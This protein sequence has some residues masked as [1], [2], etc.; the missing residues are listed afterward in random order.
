MN[1]LLGHLN[2]LPLSGSDI[3]SAIDGQA[4]VIRYSAIHEY[5]SIDELLDPYDCVVILYETQ[6]K[7]GHWTCLFLN[8]AT[9][10]LE[11]FDPYGKPIDSQLDHINPKFRKSTFQ[12]YPY[13]SRLMVKSPYYLEYNDKPLQRVGDTIN[14]CG[15]H[16]S[17]RL[18]MRNVPI[19][20]Y[21]SFLLQ[22]AGRMNPD[23]KVSMMT[24]FI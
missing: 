1:K 7:Y 17:L 6:P 20:E 24:A 21:Q 8:R 19:R 12:D 18:V 3:L 22:N 4:K 9:N 2:S 16:V 10:V 11:F 5:S 14:S 13:L 23:D 15:R